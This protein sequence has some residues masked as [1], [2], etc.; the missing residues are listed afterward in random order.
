MTKKVIFSGMVVVLLS[1][2]LYFFVLLPRENLNI[3][4]TQNTKDHY[5]S[6]LENDPTALQN[7]FV[8]DLKTGVNTKYTKSDAYF[9]T[10]RFFDN[11]GNIYEIYEYVNSHPELNFLKEAEK[12]YP[13]IFK[14]IKERT[15]PSTY[16][17][18]AYYAYLAYVEILNKYGY[19]DI[20][21][22]STV[23]NQYAKIAYYNTV[24]AKE[25]PKE[26]SSSFLRNTKRDTAKALSFISQ[27]EENIIKILNKE[28]T[29]EDVTSRDI[30]VGLNQYGAALRYL[31]AMGTSS[32]QVSPRNFSWDIFSFSTDYAARNVPEL[33]HFTSLLNASTLILDEESTSNEVKVTLYPILDLDTK[34]TKLIDKSIVHRIID[35][36]FERKPTNIGD[37]D[38]DI[39][40]KRNTLRLAN[41]VPEFKTW[42]MTNGWTEED[43]K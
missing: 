21:A 31:A 5:A 8:N 10:H 2:V 11:G 23:A 6:L 1:G 20:A 28:I 17:D 35:S 38:M 41:K 30:L 34:K 15:L 32:R 7:S 36:R 40:G 39:Y 19:T 25:V 14:A 26:K 24:L 37:T 16:V 42:L 3:K 12:I 18:R 13:S 33:M 43:F 29:S 4:I 27:S 22:I 9:I